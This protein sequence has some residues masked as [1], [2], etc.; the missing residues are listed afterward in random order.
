[1]RML[2]FQITSGKTP[3]TLK[4]L[5]LG[6]PMHVSGGFRREQKIAN[7]IFSVILLCW[8]EPDRGI[9]SKPSRWLF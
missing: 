6:K 5:F 1:M 8:P 2:I 4:S 9:E 7:C 3:K